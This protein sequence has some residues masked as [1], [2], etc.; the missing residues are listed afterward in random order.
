MSRAANALSALVEAHGRDQ[1]PL[2]GALFALSLEE[3][4]ELD[5]APYEA[6]LDALAARVRALTHRVGELQAVR[7][8]LFEEE[9]FAGNEAQYYDRENSFL[10]EVMDRRLGLPI[11]LS[12]IYVEVVRRA[13]GRADGVG[14]PGH[15]LVRHEIAGR[16]VLVDAFAQGTVRGEADLT[17]LLRRAAGPGA[18][19]APWMLEP[20]API[21]VV[22]RV[23]VNLKHAYVLAEDLVGAVTALDR[24]LG[25]DPD[26]AEERRD[27]GLLYGQLGLA[28]AAVRD[29]ERYVEERPEADDRARVLGLLPRLRDKR[30]Q[31][32]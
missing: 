13:G 19:L 16:P 32:N 10:H 11:T 27:R 29:L 14:F 31:L 5:P 18:E 17:A 1:L 28:A 8:A 3:Y 21:D 6:R 25:L 22:T 15:F 23:L 20:A 4:P 30:G 24:L 26:R 7:Q 2:A 12:V 9:G